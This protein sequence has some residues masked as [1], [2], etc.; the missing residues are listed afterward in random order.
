MTLVSVAYVLVLASLN[1][2]ISG[3]NW[4]CCPC[5]EPVPP[6]SLVMM[7]LLGVKLSLDVGRG[8]GGRST[9]STP[10]TVVDGKGDVSPLGQIGPVSAGSH[11]GPS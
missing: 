3:I 11:V 2:V 6:M 9:S 10:D 5:L 4:P 1:L 8:E 7:V